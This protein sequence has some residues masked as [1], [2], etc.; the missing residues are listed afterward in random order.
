MLKKCQLNSF[1]QM[2]KASDFSGTFRGIF[3]TQF[4]FG[5]THPFWARFILQKCRGAQMCVLRSKKAHSYELR[6]LQLHSHAS[7][8]SDAGEG[9]EVFDLTSLA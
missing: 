9:P 6:T 7:C 4:R 3:R 5:I 1:R 2:N 8:P